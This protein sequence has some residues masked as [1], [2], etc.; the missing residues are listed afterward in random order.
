MRIKCPCCGYFTID[1]DLEIIVD[2][3]QVCHWQ[4]DC[5]GHEKPNMSI[6]PNHVSLNEAIRNYKKYGASDIRFI[7]YVRKPLIE[8]LPKNNN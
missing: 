6:G 4:Y 7:P 8:E 1:N 5:V 2:I 3:C